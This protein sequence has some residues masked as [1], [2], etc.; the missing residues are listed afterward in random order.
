MRAGA[1]SGGRA[2]THE[3]IQH[4]LRDLA[5]PDQQQGSGGLGK[6]NPAGEASLWQVGGTE[7]N[8]KLNSA[9]CPVLHVLE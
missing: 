8:Y 4:G 2:S 6:G 7:K 5:R 1:L 3:G 9:G